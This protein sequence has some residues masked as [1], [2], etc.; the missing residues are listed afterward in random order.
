MAYHN[1]SPQENSKLANLG[2]RHVMLTYSM[3]QDLFTVDPGLVGHH[4]GQFKSVHVMSLKLLP[5]NSCNS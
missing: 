5:L 4:K 2:L 1:I 3:L